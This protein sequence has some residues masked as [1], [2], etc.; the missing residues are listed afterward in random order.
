MI[1]IITGINLKYDVLLAVFPVSLEEY[2]KIKS[3]L[4][5]NVRKEGIPITRLKTQSAKH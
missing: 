3:P 5:M 2:H 1:D 4:P